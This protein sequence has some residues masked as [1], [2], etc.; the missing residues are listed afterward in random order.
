MR[1]N[2]FLHAHYENKVPSLRLLQ[3]WQRIPDPRISRESCIYS[4]CAFP[5]VT[6]HCL[7]RAHLLQVSKLVFW[8]PVSIHDLLSLVSCDHFYTAVTVL[9]G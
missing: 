3:L 5:P 8:P 1:Q 9:T 7:H 2:I 6:L 4:V